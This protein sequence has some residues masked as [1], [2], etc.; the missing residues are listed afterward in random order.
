[1]EI[2]YV[3]HKEFTASACEIM[4]LQCH[5]LQH[6]LYHRTWENSSGV[7]ICKSVENDL[8]HGNFICK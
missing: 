1:M 3:N 2:P 7:Y 6:G 8:K 4:F 5:Q